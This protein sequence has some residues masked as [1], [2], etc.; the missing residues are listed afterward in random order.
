MG[1]TVGSATSQHDHE[2]PDPVTDRREF[3]ADVALVGKLL[4]ATVNKRQR[5]RE[6]AQQFDWLDAEFGRPAAQTE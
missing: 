1:R 2:P 4:D 3:G 5:R 6:L